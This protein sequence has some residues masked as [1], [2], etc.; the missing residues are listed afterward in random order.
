METSEIQVSV[1]VPA[2]NAE[3]TLAR[4]LQSVV[5]QIGCV[6]EAIVVDDGSH[7]ET[8][9]IARK[10][11][12]QYS[13]IRYVK[14]E[15][16]GVSGARN[17]G[18]ELAQGKYLLFLDADDELE[19]TMCSCLLEYARQYP[20]DMIVC[21]FCTVRQGEIQKQIAAN[22]SCCGKLLTIKEAFEPL[23]WG[24]L[25]NQPW[26]KLFRRDRVKHR[27]NRAKKNGEDLEFVLEF[28]RGGRTLA[29]S[30][31]CLY[32]NHV[33]E[34][35]SLSRNYAV[36][37]K[38]LKKNQLYLMHYLNEEAVPIRRN[39]IADYLISQLWSNMVWGN[40]VKGIALEQAIEW[41]G[42]DDG[43]RKM[44]SHLRPRK[45]GNRVVWLLVVSGHLRIYRMFLQILVCIK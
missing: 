38:D 14:Q 37:L 25:L 12:E 3:K 20:A 23:F 42:V 40:K 27:F 33:D 30:P 41:I 34:E 2:Y 31:D 16:T 35:N 1:I 24:L 19:T 9:E 10:Y 36:V 45:L 13:Y 18:I 28:M 29:V 8:G 17:R 15:N 39:S 32:R 22:L 44:L 43:Y 26:N 5:D 4:C 6:L 11:A 7:D 21:G